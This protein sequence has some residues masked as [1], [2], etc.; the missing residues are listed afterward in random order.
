MSVKKVIFHLLF[1]FLPLFLFSLEAEK[2][3]VGEGKAKEF[4]EARKLAHIDVIR[5]AL[6][7]LISFKEY[8]NYKESLEKD[9]LIYENIRRYILG[10]T[11]KVSEEKKKKWIANFR[12]S[13]GNL[14]LKLRAYVKLR[15]LKNDFENWKKKFSSSSKSEVVTSSSSVA[16]SLKEED[17]SSVDISSITM[18][19]F[20][21]PK[22]P[23]ILQ[24]PEE[25]TY[26][27][28]AVDNLN[29]EMAS[30]GIQT[31]DLET[32][33]KLSGE[34]EILQQAETGNIGIGLLLAQKVFA[35]LYAEV[36]PSVYYEGT[37]AHVILNVK[38]FVRT[39]GNLIGSIEKGG[40]MYDSPTVHASIKASMRE[41]SK[42]VK[43]ELVNSIKKY[44]AKGR[45]YF[46]RLTGVE[47]YKQASSFVQQVK[48]IDGVVSIKLKSGSK[49][50][51]TYDYDLQYK[52]SPSDFVDVALET[53]TQKPG[54]ESLDLKQIRGN[55]IIFSLE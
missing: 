23:V 15:E 26:A 52:G 47:N 29:K 45:A 44:V 22:S 41:A 34:R 16:S 43:D 7:Y 51:K 54:F 39:T 25:E 6:I 9:F 13:E 49:E 5:N 2:D 17:Y 53:L 20:Y 38:V 31:F 11:E 35:E 40:Q 42:K 8:D 50:D 33:E 18:L 14:V 21:N 4:T 12:D 28:W 36:S 32:M 46:V 55:E 10:E 19:V 24:N 30:V 1:L 48:K 37:K 27:K 3:F